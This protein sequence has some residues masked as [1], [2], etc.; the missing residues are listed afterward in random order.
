MRPESSLFS[1]EHCSQANESHDQ[2]MTLKPG[3]PAGNSERDERPSRDRLSRHGSWALVA[4]GLVVAIIAALGVALH[5]LAVDD[6]FVTYR[7]A[8]NLASGNGLVY[9]AGQPVLSTT[10]PLWAVVLAA[11]AL[12]LPN[13]PALAN[14]VSAA[15][16]A[17]GALMLFWAGRRASMPWVG[18]IA[19]LFFACYPLLWL[20][21]GLE[22]AVFLALALAAIFAV[23]SKHLYWAAVLLALATLA[24]GD[25]LI[26]A[27]VVAVDCAGGALLRRLGAPGPRWLR[28][29]IGVF[30][31][32]QPE[33]ATWRTA[34]GAAALYVAVTLPFLAWLTWQFGSPLPATLVAKQA[35]AELGVTGFYVHTTYLQG[36]GILARARLAQSPLYALF[37]PAV[38]AGLIAMW[39][40]AG[41]VR[42]LVAWGVAH[43]AGYA[44]LGVTPYTWYY[45]PLVP[46]LASISALG[47]V[48]VGRWLA[49]H[50]DVTVEQVLA[51]GDA[52]QGEPPL[53]A[54]PE[55][56][57]VA[58]RG[59]AWLWAAAILAALIQSDW[60]IVQGLR[61]PLPPPSDPVSKVLP[62]AKVDVYRQAGIWLA[63]HTPADA[64]VGVTEVGVM[65]YYARRPMVDFLGL[66][67]PDVAQAVG[68][69]DLYWALLQYQPD[70]LVLTA[71]SPL[72]ATD[73]RADPWFQAAYEPLQT[74]NDPRFWGSPLTIYERQVPREAMAGP[75]AG[76]VPDDA[77]PLNVDL[78]GRIRLLGAVA[79]A[80]SV[81]PGGILA[82]T[83]YWQA[84]RPVSHD[85]TV[86]VHLLGQY[87]RVIAQRDVEPGL[88]ARPTSGWKPGEVVADPYLLVLPEAAYAPDQAV[89]EVGLYDAAT[90]QRLP[91]DGGGD[92]VR[93]GA[94]AVEPAAQPLYLSFGRA[95]LTGYDLDR[96][97]LAAGEALTVTLQ[98][99]R[100][101]PAYVTVRLVSESGQVSVQASGDLEQKRYVLALDRGAPPGLYDL[102]VLVS[103]PATGQGLPL[104]GS[105]GQPQSDRAR[106][107]TV[108][109]YPQKNP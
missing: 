71:V 81:Q 24:R 27:A 70:Y 43:L 11:G 86:F 16:L 104:L 35:Q 73:L 107:T 76:G 12:L 39:R 33:A 51:S 37:L 79:D 103:D 100:R 97:A 17:A 106:L 55:S 99:G 25:G 34:A 9:N 72:F 52:A 1:T 22:T 32:R 92:N 59:L 63:E 102:E 91:V 8:Q 67:E 58:I 109:L 105:D 44:L 41:W 56:G 42:L 85:Y 48:A 75:A 10:A 77:V 60:A 49:G 88:G 82:L 61:G 6:A 95:A 13:V 18:F 57:R 19:A 101:G 47:I 14:A 40:R 50:R 36:L 69:G 66:L 23:R 78:G 15:A 90:G 4:V 54:V 65:G 80:S 20:G 7:Y 62:E 5:P 108:R 38:V 2:A 68:R 64:L 29:L 26:L 30:Q 45:A 74:L 96:L 94:V 31:A 93:F 28:P 84:L 21:L 89:W 98:W 46:A 87:D 83:L 53:L 3:Q